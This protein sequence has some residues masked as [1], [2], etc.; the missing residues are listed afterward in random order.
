MI[1]TLKKTLRDPFLLCLFGAVVLASLLPQLGRNGG[2]LRLDQATSVGIFAIFFLN[3]VSLSM[4]RLKQGLSRWPVHI[5]VQLFTF[6][7]F[8]LLWVAAH[9][10]F[11]SLV[12]ND[13]MLGFY[14]LCALPSTISSSVAMT[15]AARGNVPA[16]IF[17]ATFSTLVGIVITPALVGLVIDSHGQGLDITKAALDVAKLVALPFVIGQVLRPWLGGFF[18]KHKKGAFLVDRGVIVMLVL[19]SFS[20]SVAGGLWQTYGLGLIGTAFIGCIVLLAVVLALSTWVSRRFG[21][22]LEDEVA[23]VFCGSKKTLATGIP[24]A[25]LLF[26]ANPML[27]VIV[28]P[29]MLFHPLQLLACTVLAQRYAKR[30]EARDAAVVVASGSAPKTA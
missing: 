13:L 27:G 22:T 15:S 24:M 19:N 6:V 26:G 7:V 29:I 23:T 25:S 17:N 8:P 21:F 18:T 30:I 1:E 20:E 11:G 28:L 10:L 12:P 3:G 4:E 16:A 2:W 9:F 5:V 14:Y